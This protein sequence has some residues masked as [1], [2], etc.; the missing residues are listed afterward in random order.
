[1]KIEVQLYATLFQYLPKGA[2]NRRAVMEFADGITVGQVINQL[3]IPTQH[4]NMVLV[5]GTHAQE[6]APLKDGDVLSVFPPIAGGRD[7]PGSRRRSDRTL[8]CRASPTD[9]SRFR[10][11]PACRG[12]PCVP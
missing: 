8:A 6:D 4:Q 2:Q 9:L 5:N 1:M 12:T 10:R 7:L 3:G 11:Q